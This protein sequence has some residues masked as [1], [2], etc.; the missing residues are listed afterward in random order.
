[1]IFSFSYANCYLLFR[2]C[3]IYQLL[4]QIDRLFVVFFIFWYIDLNKF[5]CKE[6]VGT[7]YGQQDNLYS[8]WC[9]SDV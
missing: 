2:K 7:L 1:M 5:M 6:M 4:S 9:P 8:S 3:F